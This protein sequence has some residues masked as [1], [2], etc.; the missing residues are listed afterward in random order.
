MSRLSDAMTKAA[1][2]TEEKLGELLEAR[3]DYRPEAGGAVWDAMKYS[4]MAGG[5]RIRPYLVMEV[6]RSLSGSAERCEAEALIYACALE[7][8]HTYSLIHDDLPCMDND[9]LRRGKPCCHMVYGEATAMLA[10]DGL[11][12]LAFE[13][14]AA[15]EDILAVRRIQ[16]VKILSE[17]SGAAG[18]IGGQ[19]MD[20]DGEGQSIGYEQMVQM[21]EKKT[22]ALIIAACK[23]GALAAGTHYP[24]VWEAVEAY[25]MGIG[26]AFQLV[27][28]LLDRTATAEQTG[29][30][31]GSDL[32]KDKT[33]YLSFL[34][35]EAAKELARAITD[36]AKEAIAFYDK[37]GLLTALAESLVERQK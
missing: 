13:T 20:L 34:P 24:E 27:D 25:G 10:G 21:H 18:M 28:D 29:K 23:L 8:I 11:L 33:T 3:A 12:T 31:A 26:R 1:V 17:A 15:Q 2:Q 16:A 35:V 37:N 30:D 22:C 7:M 5:K 6:C 19:Q 14:V 9:E 32:K 4:L 36:K